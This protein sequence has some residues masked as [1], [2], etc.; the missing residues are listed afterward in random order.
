MIEESLA[1]KTSPLVKSEPM[2][3]Y[4][5]ILLNVSVFAEVWR[6]RV[7]AMMEVWARNLPKVVS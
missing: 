3:A 1:T 6:V 5:I 2:Y 7:V 4:L